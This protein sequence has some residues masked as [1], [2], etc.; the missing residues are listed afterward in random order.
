M[1]NQPQ[2]NYIRGVL[3]IIMSAFCFACMNVC[4]RFAGDLPSIQK[5]FFRNL[6]AAV[7]AGIII[8]KNNHSSEPVSLRIP[9]EA[10]PAL[11]LRCAFG[12]VGILCN[13]YA[14][15][16][17]LVADASILNKLSPFFAVIFSYFLLKEK[18]LPFQ[19]ACIFSAFLGCLFIVKPGFHNAALLPA[20]IGVCGGLGAGIAYTMVRKLGMMKIKGPVIVFYFSLFSCLFVTPWIVMDFAPMTWHQIFTLLLTG[21]FAA[22]G[23]FAITAAYTYA[24]AKKISIFDYSQIIFAAVLGFALFGEIPDGYSFLGYALVIGASAVMFWYNCRQKAS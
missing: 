16:H 3:M 8:I 1:R 19:A 5:S 11:F 2:D 18:I 12:T 15:D 6:V 21:L 17:L 9:K 22:G 7:F 24:P 14:V 13:F 10:R 4:I 20:L 23:Q